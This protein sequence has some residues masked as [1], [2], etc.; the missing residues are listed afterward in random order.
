MMP[1]HS[2][3]SQKHAKLASVEREPHLHRFRGA[4]CLYGSLELQSRERVSF[5][6][7]TEV[8]SGFPS[9]PSAAER[10]P[11]IDAQ[12]REEGLNVVEIIFSHSLFSTLQL[13]CT[14]NSA[15]FI[16]FL[17]FLMLLV[18]LPLP[19]FHQHINCRQFGLTFPCAGFAK[20]H[21]VRKVDLEHLLPAR[22]RA[23]ALK[24]EEGSWQGAGEEK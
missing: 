15:W 6:F 5:R 12:S 16:Q 22:E 4:E 20:A 14:Q 1:S 21:V 9:L 2:Y 11:G 3:Y 8:E 23:R 19:L 24:E 13:S 10:Q 18:C 7:Q 17:F